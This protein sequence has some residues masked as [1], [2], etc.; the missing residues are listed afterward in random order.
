MRT[1]ASGRPGTVRSAGTVRRRPRARPRSRASGRRGPA[2]R[3]RRRRSTPVTATTAGREAPQHLPGRRELGARAA[4]RPARSGLSGRVDVGERLRRGGGE[5]PR[6]GART[7]PP[8]GRATPP[9]SPASSC[10]S[11]GGPPSPARPVGVAR[12]V[13]SGRSADDATTDGRG[14]AA[15]RLT[16]PVERTPTHAGREHARDHE[17][18]RPRADAPVG[19]TAVSQPLPDGLPRR[20]PAGR[21]ARTIV[22]AGRGRRPGTWWVSS[23]RGPRPGAPRLGVRGRP[24]P[25]AAPAPGGRRAAGR[26][27][28][29]PRSRGRADR[30]PARGAMTSISSGGASGASSARSGSRPVGGDVQRVGRGGG[31]PGRD[32]GERVEGRRR[33]AEHVGRRTGRA[34]PGDGGVD[35]GRGDLARRRLPQDPGHAEVGQHRPPLGGEDDVA[36]REV[37]VDDAVAVRVGQGRRHRARSR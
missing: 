34:A 36:R 1:P 27:R 13:V 8:P 23:V 25:A 17:R 9:R 15:G 33:D 35:V 6:R 2:G 20:P 21:P 5:R 22:G 29:P 14:S 4:R 31:V 30:R 26:A 11:A 37:P 10:R 24:P 7:A 16:A 28:T 19:R 18:A 3:G 12:A 32:A